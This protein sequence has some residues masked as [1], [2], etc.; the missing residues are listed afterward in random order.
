MQLISNQRR[1]LCGCEIFILAR[2]I[3]YSLNECR[4]RHII[5]LELFL[6]VSRRVGE[7]HE[8]ILPGVPTLGK[9]LPPWTTQYY[10]TFPITPVVTVGT[11]DSHD[12]LCPLPSG[13]HTV[14]KVYENLYR[15]TPSG[16]V[17][18]HGSITVLP[19]TNTTPCSTVSHNC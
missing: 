13:C 4:S 16:D 8:K 18:S 19:L 10:L 15:G 2:S 14:G 11:T 17:S 12:G 5:F 9:Y 3:Q 1:D 6:V 7:G